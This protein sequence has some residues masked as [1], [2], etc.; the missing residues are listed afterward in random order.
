MK[1]G[2]Q[3]LGN[4]VPIHAPLIPSPL[5][6]YE[7]PNNTTLSAVVRSTE[8]SVKEFLNGPPFDYVGREIVISIS[9]FR[10]CTKMPFMD[11]GVILPVKYGSIQGGYYLFEYEDND[12]A[13]AAGRELWGYPKKQAD[14]N[15]AVEG[16][17]AL[18]TVVRKGKTILQLRCQLT[19]VSTS[20]PRPKI[21]PHINI[22]TVPRADGPGVLS[23]RVIAR[24][25]SPDFRVV[26]ERFGDGE[27]H[28]E[29]LPSDPL[30]RLTIEEVLSCSLVVGDFFATEKNGWGRV[31]ETLV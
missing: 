3:V 19:R 1:T 21:T 24:D 2:L 10:N 13:I 18:A 17:I 25:T 12:A 11:C 14:I 8:G 4:N 31:L 7:C 15:L 5:V 22:H 6:P 20:V 16:K 30:S 23:M 27:I 26:S 29:D 28:L 9:D